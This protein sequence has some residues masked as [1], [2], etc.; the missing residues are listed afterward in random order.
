MAG[1]AATPACHDRLQSLS[2]LVDDRLTRISDLVESRQ[3]RPSGQ[4]ALAEGEGPGTP[5]KRSLRIGVYPLA[6]NP[7]HWGHILVGLTALASMKLDKVVYIIAGTDSRKPGMVS[8]A[9]RHRLGRRII[10]I[11]NPLFAYSPLALGADLDGETNF[12]RLLDLNPRQPF[13]AFYIAG[14]DHYRRTTARGEPDT[15]GKLE[16][17]VER[18]EE[19]GRTLHRISAIFLDRLGVNP[20]QGGISTFLKVSFLPLIPFSFS[21]TAVRQALRNDVFTEALVSLP[22]SSLLE[23]VE[24]GLYRDERKSPAGDGLRVRACLPA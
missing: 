5:G 6:A 14:G 9:A 23:I 24:G 12:G 18:Q 10:E 19:A 1:L 7:L 20:L 22:H 16:R 3:I 21:S 2:A 8:A 17:L 13:E 4:L 11:F 15:I